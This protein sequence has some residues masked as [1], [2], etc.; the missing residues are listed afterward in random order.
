M[1][2]IYMHCSRLHCMPIVAKDDYDHVDFP[3]TSASVVFADCYPSST[4]PV[5]AAV[6]G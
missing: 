2:Y 1:C 6:S 3:T 5:I 4:S